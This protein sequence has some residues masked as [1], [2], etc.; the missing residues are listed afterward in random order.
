MVIIM[1]GIVTWR[2]ASQ[3]LNDYLHMTINIE[4]DPNCSGPAVQVSGG[5]QYSCWDIS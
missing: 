5:V 3:R 2:L 1:F 4:I